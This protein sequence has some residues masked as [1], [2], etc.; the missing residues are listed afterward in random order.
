MTGRL[1][2]LLHRLRGSESERGAMTLFVAVV[3]TSLLTGIGLIYDGS[4]KI[5][6]AR[7]ATSIASEAAR[8][9]GQELTGEAILGNAST[10]DPSRGVIAA[11]AYLGAVGAEGSVAINGT[12]ITVTAHATWTP[13]F[14]GLFGAGTQVETGSAS[15]STRRVLGGSEQ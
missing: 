15:A 6:A 8:A 1:R 10:V 4:L 7:T 5:A 2:Q 14:L 12:D 3:A 11:R 9:A 13:H